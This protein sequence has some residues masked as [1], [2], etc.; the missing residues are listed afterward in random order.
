MLTAFAI[1]LHSVGLAV[2]LTLGA[3]DPQ[4]TDAFK[5]LYSGES[6]RALRLSS[7]YLKEHPADVNALVLA[8]RAEIARDHY[9]AA[10]DLLRKALAAD[11]RNP[12]VLYFLG[13]VSSQL[14]ASAFDR[15]GELAPDGARVHQLLARSLQLQEKPVEAAAE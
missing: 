9:N 4:L 12:D 6:D 1:A 2:A 14:A 3:T 10:Y 7:E 5:A 15:L 11:P 8:A 13:V